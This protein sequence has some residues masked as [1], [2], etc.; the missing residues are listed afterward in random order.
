MKYLILIFSICFILSACQST[1]TSSSGSSSPSASSS[2]SSTSNGSSS[3]G[4]SSGKSAGSTANTGASTGRASGGSSKSATPNGAANGSDSNTS[5]SGDSTSQSSDES[6]KSIEGPGDG[7]E[8]LPV[9]ETQPNLGN[10]STE[11][12]E[13]TG[14]SSNAS[15]EEASLEDIQKTLDKAMQTFDEEILREQENVRD[16]TGNNGSGAQKR[17]DNK[18][19]AGVGE[20]DIYTEQHNNDKASSSTK[21]NATVKADDAPAPS[22]DDDIV[23]RQIREAASSESDPKQRAIL[24]EE[25]RRYKRG[26]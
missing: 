18:A 1:S 22:P 14:A 3:P 11:T 26:Q 23:A 4:T 19:L 15:Y 5:S 8:D 17:S 20:F 13:S 12:S 21:S 7:A 2:G 16:K 25:Y 24:W 10:Q 9:W 6:N